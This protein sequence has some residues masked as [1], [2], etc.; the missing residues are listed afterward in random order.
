MVG[1][2]IQG[3]HNFH[4][5]FYKNFKTGAVTGAVVG[6]WFHF[7]LTEKA[8]K[9]LAKDHNTDAYMDARGKGLLMVVIGAII[10]TAVGFLNSQRAG[11][12]Q[13]HPDTVDN[14]LA[15]FSLG[16]M[17]MNYFELFTDNQSSVPSTE[18]YSLKMGF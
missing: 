16:L 11:V 8:Y 12:E 7:N 2:P 5:R 14:A 13:I 17:A 9:A 4:G 18:P 3:F 10:G 1:E 6:F 15:Y